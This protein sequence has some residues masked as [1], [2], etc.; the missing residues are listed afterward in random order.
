ML[1]DDDPLR[2][3]AGV[4]LGCLIGAV[5]WALILGGIV[6]LCVAVVLAWG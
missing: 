2:P 1:E 6:L 3:A 5:A 4:A